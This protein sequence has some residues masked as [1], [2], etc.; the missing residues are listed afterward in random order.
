[1]SP[2]NKR[3]GGVRDLKDRRVGVV[4]GTTTI[5]SLEA[6]LRK[7]A[8]AAQVVTFDQAAKGLD[9]LRKGEIDAFASDQVVLIGLALTAKD[10][11]QFF[12]TEEMFSF[13]PFA[14]AVQRNDADFRLLADS[15]LSSLYRSGKIKEIYGRWFGGLP[16]DM[17]EL[18]QA[19]YQL[20]ATPE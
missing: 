7:T 1:M 2:N 17:P 20:N 12:I 6:A 8:T 16:F 18:L 5:G 3:V 11:G 9:A 14:L 13:E 10:G 19:L 15:V 4:H